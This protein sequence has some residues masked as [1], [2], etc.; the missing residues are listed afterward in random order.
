MA[1][2][3]DN[4][5]INHSGAQRSIQQ[6]ESRTHSPLVGLTEQDESGDRITLSQYGASQA[7]KAPAT[8]VD[9]AEAAQELLQ[10]LRDRMEQSP[11]TALLAHS[12]QGNHLGALL[13]STMA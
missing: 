13:Q 9:S 11:V 7:L 10:G 6:P 2:T 8:T 3:I 4:N 12:N 5:L 1:T